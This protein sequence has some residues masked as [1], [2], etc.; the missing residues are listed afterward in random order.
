MTSKNDRKRTR[1]KETINTEG[2]KTWK[3]PDTK[4]G[5]TRSLF[6]TFRIDK[7]DLDAINEHCERDGIDRSVLMRS[8][9]KQ[10][11]ESLKKSS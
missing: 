8:I 5:V 10:F 9:V 11:L 3:A 1:P 2:L 4:K 7:E 6:P